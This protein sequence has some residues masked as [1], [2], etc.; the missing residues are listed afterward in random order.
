MK[1]DF[2]RPCIFHDVLLYMDIE[3]MHEKQVKIR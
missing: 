2:K 3:F 1:I